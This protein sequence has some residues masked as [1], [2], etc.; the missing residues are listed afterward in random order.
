M[1]SET[2]LP[3]ST[4]IFIVLKQPE[5]VFNDFDV[6]DRFKVACGSKQSSKDRVQTLQ[7]HSQLSHIHG[8]FFQSCCDVYAEGARDEGARSEYEV[9]LDFAANTKGSGDPNNDRWSLRP[10]APHDG[11]GHLVVHKTYVTQGLQSQKSSILSC[12]FAKR[13][14]L[15]LQF[16]V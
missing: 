16:G 13:R 8:N 3:S 11:R 14:T 10:H 9:G 5:N 4:Q 6:A 1:F 12:L 7:A 15:T 2:S